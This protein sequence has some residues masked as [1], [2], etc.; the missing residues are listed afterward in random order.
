[1]IISCASQYHSGVLNFSFK[2]SQFRWVFRSTSGC[3]KC[4][5]LHSVPPLQMMRYS[6]SKLVG[7]LLWQNSHC[8]Y[9]FVS[10]CPEW[11]R[12]EQ[13][14]SRKCITDGQKGRKQVTRNSVG[15]WTP[16][17]GWPN[18]RRYQSQISENNSHVWNVS[19][20]VVMLYYERLQSAV[21]CLFWPTDRWTDRTDHIS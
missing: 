19:Y 8:L 13:V 3:G 12:E 20:L 21:W 2:N 18:N 14:V 17:T 10:E 5:C 16:P 7:I 9:T 6:G 1:M 11:E 4:T 15:N